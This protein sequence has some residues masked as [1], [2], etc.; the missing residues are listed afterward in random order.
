MHWKSF[1]IKLKIELGNQPNSNY[2]SWW[3]GIKNS[4]V[5]NRISEKNWRN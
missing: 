4:I 1:F 5:W 3:I 2:F